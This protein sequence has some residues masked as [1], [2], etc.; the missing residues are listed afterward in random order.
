M[1]LLFESRPE[2]RGTTEKVRFIQRKPQVHPQ[3]VLTRSPES[4]V[5]GAGVS[6]Y[7]TVLN[8]GGSFRMW[9][10]GWPKDW[11]GNNGREDADPQ[12]GGGG[13]DLGGRGG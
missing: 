12:H 1:E 2:V 7:G 8:E 3:P 4:A 6:I 10:Q 9:Y 11:N 13:Y 5:D